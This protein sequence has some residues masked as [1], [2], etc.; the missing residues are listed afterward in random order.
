MSK[1]VI[2]LGIVLLAQF[3]QGGIRWIFP[4]PPHPH[5]RVTDQNI[6]IKF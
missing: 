4:P 3:L 1:C 2:L 6:E 5:Q